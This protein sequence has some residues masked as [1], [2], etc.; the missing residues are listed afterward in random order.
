MLKWISVTKT[1]DESGGGES[2][3]NRGFWEF[4]RRLSGLENRAEGHTSKYRILLFE[5]WRQYADVV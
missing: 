2:T 4:R 5:P 3:E 1:Y